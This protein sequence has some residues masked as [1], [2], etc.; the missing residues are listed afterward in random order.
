[1]ADEK[2]IERPSSARSLKSI[3][4]EGTVWIRGKRNEPSGIVTTGKSKK[5]KEKEKE[6]RRAFAG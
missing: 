2:A 6:S 5:K 3:I 1:M 4:S